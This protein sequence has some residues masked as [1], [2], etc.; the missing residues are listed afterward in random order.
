[1]I[2]TVRGSISTKE[3]GRTF[4]HEHFVFGFP[5]YSGDLTLGRLNTEK[6]I[7]TGVEKAKCL[8]KNNITTVIDCTPNDCGRMPDILREISIQTGLNIICVTGFYNEESGAPSYFKNRRNFSDIE[9]EIFEMFVEEI[10]NGIEGT[11]IK[12][13]V[14]KVASSMDCITEYEK[15]FFRAAAKAQRETGTIIITHTTD[16]TMALEQAKL[17]IDEGARPEKIIIGHVCTISDIGCLIELLD[18]GV[19]IGFDRFGYN[20]DEKCNDITRVAL[21]VGL[22][23]IGYNNKILVSHDMLYSKLGRDRAPIA[24]QKSST[25]PV[26]FVENIIPKLKHAQISSAQIEKLLIENVA[27]VFGN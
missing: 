25:N 2:N 7:Q 20:R 26:H 16:G 15:N 23:G 18:M 8:L 27:D 6:I 19:Y 11:G 5:G 10:N 22:M 13:G 4:C 1:M 14:I 21:I 24:L 3:L 9:K 17:L 12:P